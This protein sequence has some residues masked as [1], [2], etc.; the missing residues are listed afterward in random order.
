MSTPDITT[1]SSPEAV[2]PLTRYM[3]EDYLACAAFTVL[4]LDVFAQFFSRYALGASIP[5]TEEAA[6][7]LLIAVTFLGAPMALRRG[8][9]IAVDMVHGYTTPRVSK[10]FELLADLVSLAFLIT[11]TVLCVQIAQ[12]TGGRM[13]G[14]PL[15]KSAVYWVA[16][17]GLALMV[18][19]ALIDLAHLLRGVPRDSQMGLKHVD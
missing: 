7:Y 13:I 2:P 4:A 8:E 6:R 11:L 5:W 16:A 15:P 3:P 1:A 18:L 17:A 10:A 19:R 12:K 9:H 14:L